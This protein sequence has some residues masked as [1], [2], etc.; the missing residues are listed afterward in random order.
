M[1]LAFRLPALLLAP[2]QLRRPARSREG[3][4]EEMEDIVVFQPLEFL[5]RRRRSLTSPTSVVFGPSHFFFESLQVPSSSRRSRMTKKE[6]NLLMKVVGRRA[7]P[8]TLQQSW[9]AGSWA[10]RLAT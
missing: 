10:G 9:P 7:R 5:S 6:S 8:R 3:C 2:D 1:G 4:V